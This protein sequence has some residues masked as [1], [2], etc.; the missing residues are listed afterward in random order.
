[1]AANFGK[2]AAL[3]WRKGDQAITIAITGRLRR[4]RACRPAGGRG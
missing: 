4:R 1:M 3:A 2:S